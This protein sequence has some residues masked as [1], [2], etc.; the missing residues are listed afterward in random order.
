MNF[1]SINLLQ[2]C[3]YSCGNFADKEP[4]GQRILSMGLLTGMIVLLI[5]LPIALIVCVVVIPWQAMKILYS[6]SMR[7]LFCCCC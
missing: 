7:Y 2:S 5:S 3:L 1:V 4:D 6:F